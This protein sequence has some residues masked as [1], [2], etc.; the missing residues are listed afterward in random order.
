MQTATDFRFNVS[1]ILS[2]LIYARI[3]HPCSTSKTFVEVIPKLFEQHAFSLDQLY[4]GLEYLGDEYEKIIEIYNHQITQKYRF[5]TS[6]SYFDCTNF[7]FEIDKEDDFRLKEPS[8]EN[9]KIK[10]NLLSDW[11]CCSMQTRFRSA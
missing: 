5:D 3:V 7:Y 4:S 9:K 10:K 8:K 1:E 11:D 6:H 2:A